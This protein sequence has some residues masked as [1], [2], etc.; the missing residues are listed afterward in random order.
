MVD[1]IGSFRSPV[2]HGPDWVQSCALGSVPNS[3]T[4]TIT[5]RFSLKGAQA[6]RMDLR[7]QGDEIVFM[8]T[9]E[10]MSIVSDSA[11][12]G[13]AGPGARSVEIFG[14]DNNFTEFVENEIVILDGLTPVLTTR[15]YRR[16]NDVRVID[17]GV[18]IENTGTLTVTAEIAGTEQ[19]C[20]TPRHN[21]TS[22]VI[23][24][25]PANKTVIIYNSFVSAAKGDNVFLD[26]A[27]RQAGNNEPFIRGA[28][29]HSYEG[30]NSLGALNI[31]FPSLT[32]FKLEATPDKNMASCTGSIFAVQF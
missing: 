10:R 4:I 31:A 15:T 11:D 3:E 22:Q 2:S 17:T 19:T 8:Q 13:P 29:T 25:V 5:G 12:D 6:V 24:T 16:I 9:A 28:A 30:N 7:P 32:D 26:F 14:L 27:F 18:N 20:I 23:Y 21:A 1:F